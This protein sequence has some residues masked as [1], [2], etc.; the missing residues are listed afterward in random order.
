MG[1][2]MTRVDGERLFVIFEGEIHLRVVAMCV[3][4]R[5]PGYSALRAS[6]VT[7]LLRSSMARCPVFFRSGLPARDIVRVQLGGRRGVRILAYNPA[8]TRATRSA[9]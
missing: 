1:T 8:G 9:E 6:F 2:A 5:T 3:P 7:A 4:Q